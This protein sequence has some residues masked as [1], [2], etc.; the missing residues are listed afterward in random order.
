MPFKSCL[1]CCRIL[2]QLLTE[3]LRINLSARFVVLV[4]R[5]IFFIA[6]QVYFGHKVNNLLGGVD[7]SVKIEFVIE[8]VNCLER[9]KD[10]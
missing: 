4:T 6:S 5:K 1:R 8:N 9:K 7:R 10:L 2:L 3:I